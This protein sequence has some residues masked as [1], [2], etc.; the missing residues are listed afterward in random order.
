MATQ[1]RYRRFIGLAVTG[2]ALVVAG[3]VWAGPAQ[4]DANTYLSD[5]HSAGIQDVGGDSAL[6]QTGQKLCVQLSYGVSTNQLVS[7]ALQ[8][9]D[10]QQGA[11]GLTPQKANELVDYARGDLCPNY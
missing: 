1:R 8:R 9:S 4:A 2:G 5:L 6:L 10:A 11:R 7:L 3:T